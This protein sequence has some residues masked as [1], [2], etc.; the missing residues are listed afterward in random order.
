MTKAFTVCE[1]NGSDSTA[2]LVWT[3]THTKARSIASRTAWFDGVS[4]KDLQCNREPTVDGVRP[5]GY[6]ACD[7]PTKAD[8]WLMRALGWYDVDV[9]FL[10][11]DECGLHQWTDLPESKLDDKGVCAGCRKPHRK[12]KSWTAGK[13]KS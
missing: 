8:S 9:G 11:C 5:D 1:K 3:T 6:C 10:C 4:K 12:V 13:V 7:E 2:V